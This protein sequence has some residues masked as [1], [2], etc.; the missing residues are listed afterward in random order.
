VI[1]QTALN[2]NKRQMASPM[3]FIPQPSK[4][5]TNNHGLKTATAIGCTSLA[6]GPLSNQGN[7]CK[8]LAEKRLLA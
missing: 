2:V 3:Y 6:E 7:A 1:G 4:N 8:D 5:F